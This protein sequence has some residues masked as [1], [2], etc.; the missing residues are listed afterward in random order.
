MLMKVNLM[1]KK[2][3]GSVASVCHV[4]HP[5]GALTVTIKSKERK[6]RKKPSLSTQIDKDWECYKN[7]VEFYKKP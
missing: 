2:K 3:P 1:R 7:K 4:M 5:S 6:E